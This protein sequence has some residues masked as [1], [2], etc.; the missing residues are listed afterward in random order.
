M[1]EDDEDQSTLREKRAKLGELHAEQIFSLLTPIW[2][3]YH[4]EML[5]LL[6]QFI[7]G[8]LPAE[9]IPISSG[10]FSKLS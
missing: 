10:L 8:S 3:K 6:S 7:Q 4:C 1:D 5:T 2:V 9:Q